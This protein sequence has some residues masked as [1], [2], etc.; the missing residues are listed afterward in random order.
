[1]RE[2]RNRIWR[3][4][5]HE[6]IVLYLNFI[7]IIQLYQVFP[8]FHAQ[9]MSGKAWKVEKNKCHNSDIRVEKYVNLD[10]L[11]LNRR[12]MGG[13]YS[14]FGTKV[15]RFGWRRKAWFLRKNREIEI[16][17][18]KGGVTFFRKFKIC[19]SIFSYP[20]FFLQEIS[21]P[22]NFIPLK[23][24]SGRLSAINNDHPLSTSFYG[25]HFF[26]P[27]HLYP[28]GVTISRRELIILSVS[29]VSLFNP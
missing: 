23:I 21:Y 13:F 7:R 18:K 17:S 5:Y 15:K 8:T 1:M 19:R 9:K 20:L 10:N 24:D 28:S 6:K 29:C 12:F 2:V 25:L 14:E 11:Y 3:T 27:L 16:L 22:L 4:T 26:M